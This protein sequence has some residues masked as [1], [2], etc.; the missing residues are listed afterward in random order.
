MKERD[1]R[2]DYLRAAAV[3][4]MILQHVGIY[5][6]SPE[7]Q[8]S[9]AS[10]VFEELILL[11]TKSAVPLFVMITGAVMLDEAADKEITVHKAVTYAK[12]MIGIIVFWN[13]VSAVFTAL[14]GGTL[15]D[16]AASAVYGKYWYLYMLVG[17]YIYM[18]ISDMIVKKVELKKRETET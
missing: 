14:M 1:S 2:L 5:L 9:W 4:M 13:V 3:M 17:L 15:K 7:A 16:I 10:A 18:P 8:V 6:N 11:V 12:K